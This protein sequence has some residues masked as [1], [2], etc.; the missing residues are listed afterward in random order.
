MKRLRGWLP[1]LSKLDLRKWE[2]VLV[3]SGALLFVS[4][5]VFYFGG[6]SLRKYALGWEDDEVAQPVGKL[7]GRKGSV[8]RQTQL[9]SDFDSIEGGS[10]LYNFDTLVTG[11]DSG[12]T[13]QLD[14]GGTIDLGPS[15]MVKLAFERR[16][17]LGGIS[18]AATVE[19][20]TG[21]VTGQARSRKITLKSRV[22]TVAVSSE[23]R[24]AM[25]AF[26]EPPK[27]ILA[28]LPPPA[29]SPRPVAPLPAS[30]PS[31]SP[32]SDPRPSPNPSPGPSPSPQPA[33]VSKVL[34]KVTAPAAGARLSVPPDAQAPEREVT[35]HWN[36]R[37][38][39]A[40]FEAVL[41]RT[42]ENG[43]EVFR[44][45]LE[46]QSASASVSTVIKAAGKY[47][48]ELRPAPGGGAEFKP[49]RVP[50]EL[51]SQIQ[52]IQTLDPLVGGKPMSSN[53]YTGDHLDNFDITFRWK[54]FAKAR[55]YKIQLLSRPDS[56]KPIFEQAV[57]GL[58]YS[59][60][61][62]KVYTGQIYYRIE[63][64]LEGGFVARSEARPFMF[65]FLPP[66]PVSPADHAVLS[67][68]ALET[69]N[70]SFL[71]TWQKTNFTDAYVVQFSRDP[72]FRQVLIERKLKE[73]FF[74][75][76]QPAPG[77]YFWRVRSQSKSMSSPPTKYREL[78][79]TD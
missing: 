36:A 29:P 40:R 50:F 52:G 19:V 14:D 64:Q 21:R 9:Q 75:L 65:N 66:V 77:R 53:E 51:L 57:E 28:S 26:V 11:P 2:L 25:R 10:T 74:V 54:E 70:D 8:R 73:N 23:T 33:Q 71:L 16:L 45:A 31:P 61:K 6:I 34:V 20:V 63:A 37:P 48:W 44:K 12:A 35:L 41:R 67:K 78:I 79:V 30:A 17:A 38:V 49:V 72:K 47:E 4:S 59:F 27:P 55:K 42:G 60:N 46:A 1:D 68:K 58:Q 69:S 76:R 43:G 32:R 7:A 22:E 24:G 18:R 56:A 5:S 62:E 39:G 13:V 3:I 15:T